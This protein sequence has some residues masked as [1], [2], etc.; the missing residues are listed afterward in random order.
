MKKIILVGLLSLISS[1]YAMEVVTEKP[2]ED[3]VQVVKEVLIQ[4][5]QITILIYM[6][7]IYLLLG[8]LIKVFISI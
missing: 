3:S 6:N 7:L 4:L 1:V 8:K 2:K 5:S